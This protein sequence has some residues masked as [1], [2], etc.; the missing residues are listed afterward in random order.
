MRPRSLVSRLASAWTYPAHLEDFL[1]VIDRKHSARQLR[2]SV[3][4]VVQET[5]SVTTVSLRPGRGW[6]PHRAGQW[7]RVG[8]EVDGVRHWR[9]FSISAPEGDDPSITVGQVG[10]VTS[11][12]D[13]VRP[14]DVLFLEPPQG[15]FV[16][17][18][19]DAPALF[20]A[21]GTGIT[22]IY[23]MLATLL[24]RDP[25]AD[26]VLVHVARTDT[27]AVFAAKLDA[28]A[29]EHPRFRLVRWRSEHSGRL[30][31][32]TPATLDD[33]VPDWRERAAFACGPE[34]LIADAEALWQSAGAGEELN[35][36]RFTL[37]RRV[38][39]D[40][41]GGRVRF[42]KADVEVDAEPDASLLEVGEAAGLEL[43]HGCR[44][45]I[46]RTC[47]QKLDDG[48]VRDLTTGDVHG[49]PGD[50]I[51]MCVSG[52]AGDVDVDV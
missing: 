13:G 47:L 35:V 36:E 6:T 1:A 24:E 46:C 12:L 31:L 4:A 49:E 28:L 33:L 17:P 8:V 16:L 11:A 5:P 23:A 34:T 27:D 40:A 18:D 42:T 20:I 50:L 44:R 9:P 10:L 41:A 26:A 39:P 48:Q 37:T 14:G 32:T 29:A 7:M 38:D 52:A 15:E 43:P 51:R 2:G 30:D 21:A 25:D 22:P 45:G 3:T 19:E